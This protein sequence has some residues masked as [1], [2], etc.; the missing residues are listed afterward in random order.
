MNRL[1]STRMLVDCASLD[2]AAQRYRQLPWYSWSISFAFL[3]SRRMQWLSVHIRWHPI[4][5]WGW[6]S[7]ALWEY[8]KVFNVAFMREKLWFLLRLSRMGIWTMRKLTVNRFS[9]WTTKLGSELA[10]KDI[11]INRDISFWRADWKNSSIVEERKL[12]LLKS[13]M[14]CYHVLEL[15][16][17]LRSLWKMIFMARV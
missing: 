7:Q 2:L 5:C 9:Y 3:F 10:I 11:S 14:S 1:V 6:E 4:L 13:T 12:V 8:P 15:A 16:M 17:R